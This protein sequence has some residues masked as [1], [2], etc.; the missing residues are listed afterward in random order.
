MSEQLDHKHIYDLC[1]EHMHSYVLVEMTDGMKFDGI[2]TGLDDEHVFFAV[3]ID[4]QDQ[5]YQINESHSYRQ[6]GYGSGPGYGYS[7][8]GY[9]SGPGYSYSNPGYGYPPYNYGYPGGRFRRLV[10]PLTAIAA[11]SLL[12]WY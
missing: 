5:S 6:F 4:P 11:L 8:P 1:K 9:G 3:P 12:P 10:L 7:Y 2:V